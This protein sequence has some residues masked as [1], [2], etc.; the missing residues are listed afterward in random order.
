MQPYFQTVIES[1]A[2]VPPGAVG[3]RLPP[4][5]PAGAGWAF[6][7]TTSGAGT[8]GVATVRDR[9]HLMID[10]RRSGDLGQP[11][12]GRMRPRSPGSSAG[13]CRAPR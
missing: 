4:D 5:R 9:Q 10:M 12:P 13:E 1:E 6:A 3:E 11:T 7:A 2:R 8:C